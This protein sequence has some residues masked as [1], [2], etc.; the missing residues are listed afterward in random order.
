MKLFRNM[1]IGSKL[2]AAFS[3]MIFLI[4][5]VGIEGMMQLGQMDDLLSEL[6]N[7]R[8]VTISKVQDVDVKAYNI[9]R[10]IRDYLLAKDPNERNNQY[11]KYQDLRT[12]SRQSVETVKNVLTL[13]TEKK[14]YEKVIENLEN[15]LFSADSVINSTNNSGFIKLSE[16]QYTSLQTA[17]DKISIAD[18]SMSEFSEKQKIAGKQFYENGR[19]IYYSSKRLLIIFITL[20]VIISL[21]SGLFISDIFIKKPIRKLYKKFSDVFEIGLSNNSKEVKDEIILLSSYI[22]IIA[23]QQQKMAQ[24]FLFQSKNITKSCSNLLDISEQIE[25]GSIE[26][27]SQTDVAV[28]SSE[29]ISSSLGMISGASE[30]TTLSIKE[31]AKSTSYSTKIVNEA[32]HRAKQAGEV[33]DRLTVSSVEVGKI[34]KVINSI[35]EQTNLLA[36]NATIEAARA[37]NSGKGFAVVATEVKELSKE[38]AKATENISKIIKV[39]QDD[40]V[41]AI[42]VIKDIT[43]IT[44]QITD[45]SCNT[46]SAVEEQSITMSEINSSIS[47]SLKESLAITEVNS[48]LSSAVSD[49]SIQAQNIKNHSS[50]LQV[51]ANKLENSLKLNFKI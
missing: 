15:Y 21:V 39:I 51:L 36:L 33:M 13:D 5:I 6:Y 3:V 48:I 35:A 34:V 12:K 17:R 50:E 38:T 10:V 30:Q 47:D 22:N 16:E 43:S 29:K 23:D 7:Q 45:I 18:K 24:E 42:E 19:E 27:S 26:L 1:M 4:V 41:N 37:G 31:I 14:E 8:M 20:G 46:A 11:E 9:A 32:N 25:S 44:Q 49:Y 28:S 40:S 2:M